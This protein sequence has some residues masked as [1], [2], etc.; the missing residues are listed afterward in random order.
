MT[1]IQ[2]N[3]YNT[4][5]L[6]RLGT[7]D[8][9]ARIT[10]NRPDAMNSLSQELWNELSE[11]LRDLEADQGCR[12][13]ILRGAGKCFSAGHDLADRTGARQHK[14]HDDKGRPLLMNVRTSMQQVTD[15]YM[16]Y[17]NL[18]K[19][20]IAQI[21][22]S[23]L[24]GGCEFAMMSD[25]V[26]SS[27]NAKIGHP[28][29]RG[30][31]TARNGNIWPL[32][33]GMRKAKE[34]Y[35]TGD[36][37]SGAEAAEMGMINYAW[38]EE[39]LERFTLQLADRIANGSADHLAMLK[40]TMNRFYENMGIYSSVRSATEQ[41]AMAQ[42]T[43]WSYETNELFREKGLRDGFRARDAPY[44]GNEEFRGKKS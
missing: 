25:L 20:T 10:L 14:M 36:T 12:V 35:Y 26:V 22:G 19:I 18:A 16:H 28:G 2:T 41:D 34:Y 43:E 30:L 4:I 33:M 13:I 24:A 11:C 29:H 17:W 7:E 37:M 15:H 27:E 40:M 1:E 42:M 32:V 8:R 3:D 38:P 6:E 21:H 44:K 23:A 39:D 5:L 9:L 31:G